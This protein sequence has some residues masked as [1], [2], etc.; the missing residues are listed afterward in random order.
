MFTILQIHHFMSLSRILSPHTYFTCSQDSQL[1]FCLTC[2]VRLC[3]HFW[4]F[5]FPRSQRGTMFNLLLPNRIV[6]PSC[7]VCRLREKHV[8]HY[9]VCTKEKIKYICQNMPDRLHK[10]F[11]SR[12]WESDVENLA[13]WRGTQGRNNFLTGMLTYGFF[14]LSDSVC[15]K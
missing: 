15:N 10:D 12:E 13:G 1:C 2:R 4:S 7:S 11:S 9:R 3:S 8:R 5:E 14:S 6:L